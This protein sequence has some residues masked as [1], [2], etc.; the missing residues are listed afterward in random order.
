MIENCRSARSQTSGLLAPFLILSIFSASAADSE[1]KTTTKEKKQYP[2]DRVNFTISGTITFKG[3]PRERKPIDLSAHKGASEYY[4]DKPLL[5]ERYVISADGKVADVLIF[6]SK[7]LEEYAFRTPK[8][9]V[10]IDQLGYRFEPHVFGI[11]VGQPLIIRNRDD[12]AHN[13]HCLCLK[14]DGFNLA[15]PCRD[16]TTKKQFSEAEL[17]FR[18]QCDL[19]IWMQ[20]WCGVLDHPFFCV[21]NADG[22]FEL[23]GLIAGHYE[24]T[25]WHERLGTQKIE[26]DVGDG[27]AN[28]ASFAFGQGI[29]SA[30]P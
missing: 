1:L 18:I 4:K 17:P 9:P 3:K 13:I 30:K 20:A 24:L 7:G 25:A 28:K 10:A 21:S 5:D 8:E 23:K 14:N 29:E 12:D 16:V 19:H 2:A 27:A 26:I 22:Q 15:Q 11:M 6:V